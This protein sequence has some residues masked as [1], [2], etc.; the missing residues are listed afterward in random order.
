MCCWVLIKPTDLT[1]GRI[2]QVWCHLQH[3]VCRLELVSFHIKV[4]RPEEHRLSTRCLLDVRRMVNVTH[5]GVTELGRYIT[6]ELYDLSAGF[7]PVPTFGLPSSPLLGKQ[8]QICGC[9]LVCFADSSM[10]RR[11]SQALQQHLKVYRHVTC[12]RIPDIPVRFFFLL[13]REHFP[14]RQV[15]AYKRAGQLYK[16]GGRVLLLCSCTFVCSALNVC[17]NHTLLD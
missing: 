8:N 3:L 7:T 15:G 17:L 16:A 13:S 11:H 5:F 6:R 14:F 9:S 4:E 2:L 12:C 1:P 10:C